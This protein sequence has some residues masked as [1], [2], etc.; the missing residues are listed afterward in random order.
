[1]VTQAALST[2][3]ISFSYRVARATEAWV[4]AAGLRVGKFCSSGDT[5]AQALYGMDIHEF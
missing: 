2:K 1:M 3:P 5:R 4:M